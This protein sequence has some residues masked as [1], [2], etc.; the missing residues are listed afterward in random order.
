MV[1]RRLF[2]TWHGQKKVS[3]RS[4]RIQSSHEKI[5][6]EGQL[7]QRAWGRTELVGMLEEREDQWQFWSMVW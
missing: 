2:Y 5:W 4:L 3:E 7:M 1:T 6:T